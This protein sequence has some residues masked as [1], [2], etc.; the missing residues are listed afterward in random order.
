M[1]RKVKVI[2]QP[3]KFRKRDHIAILS[4][5]SPEVDEVVRE[6]ENAEW[7]TGYRFWHI[8]IKEGTLDYVKKELSGVA[9]T[10]DSSFEGFELKEYIEKEKKPRR[11]RVKIDSPT[12]EQKEK[13]ENFRKH[14][15]DKGY[16]EG[17]VK[18]Y[19]SMLSVFWGWH[20]DK[21]DFEITRDDIDGFIEGYIEANNFTINYKRLMT[22][23][24][25]RYFKFAGVKKFSRV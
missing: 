19:V 2:L 1:G 5:N 13:L 15:I 22:N 12:K 18:V 3:V 21:T 20:K 11:K 17:T 24:L 8:P 6:L 25:R 4:P 23:A 9:E 16:S 10:D 7:S 14:F